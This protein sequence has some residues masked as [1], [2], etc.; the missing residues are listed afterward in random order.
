MRSVAMNRRKFLKTFFS[1]VTVGVAAEPG[2][3]GSFLNVR[4]L[5]VHPGLPTFAKWRMAV[6]RTHRMAPPAAG[7]SQQLQIIR[8]VTRRYGAIDGGKSRVGS[9]LL[10]VQNLVV[11]RQS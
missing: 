10:Y 4:F 8:V 2:I 7:A 9:G 11:P 6:G 5:P 1:L 3:L